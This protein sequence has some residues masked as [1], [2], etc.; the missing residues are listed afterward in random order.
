MI[1]CATSR[2]AL[3]QYGLML[4][5][6]MSMPCSSMARRRSAGCVIMSTLGRFGWP[7]TFRFMRAMASG[8]AQCA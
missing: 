5:A 8:T 6:S 3:Y 7:V 4:S 1:F 2:S